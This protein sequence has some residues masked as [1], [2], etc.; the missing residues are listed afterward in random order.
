MA[1]A[2][3]A[4]LEDSR[5]HGGLA[6]RLKVATA[7]VERRTRWCAHCG[8]GAARIRDLGSGHTWVGGFVVALHTLLPRSCFTWNAVRPGAVG[9][10]I[11]ATRAPARAAFDHPDGPDALMASPCSALGRQPAVGIRGG[12]SRGTHVPAR[13]DPSTV[14]PIPLP[15]RVLTHPRRRV[16]AAPLRA[17][18]SHAVGQGDHRRA[19][20]RTPFGPGRWA[21]DDGTASPPD[22]PTILRDEAARPPPL[23]PQLASARAWPAARPVPYL[24]QWP[25]GPTSAPAP[26]GG[27]GPQG[28]SLER[29]RI[30]GAPQAGRG[31]S[32]A[33]PAHRAAR[34]PAQR[35]GT[36]GDPHPLPATG[37]T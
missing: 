31:R 20:R 33:R 2:R 18:R 1:P 25:P 21:L 24:L 26:R 12:V 6:P 16:P 11:G 5:R 10:Q 28:A 17:R 34:C 22:T 23:A 35:H 7:A 3:R 15:G 30:A 8:R 37:F 36:R 9:P 32:T 14:S 27:V 29:V 4:A 13:L 19:A